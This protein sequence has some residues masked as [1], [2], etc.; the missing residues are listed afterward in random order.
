M[1][2][3]LIPKL[4]ISSLIGILLSSI[5][6]E[7]ASAHGKQNSSATALQDG[8]FSLTRSPENPKQY[9]LVLSDGEEHNI[10]GNFSLDQLQILRVIMT[11]AEKFALNGEAVG[12]QDPLTTR[13]TDKEESAFL[14]DVEKLGNQSRLFLT[15]KT[16]I[17]RTTLHA[18]R[19]L[20]STKREDGFFFDLLSRLESLLP[21]LPAQRG[22]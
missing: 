19:V 22:K 7:A 8:T 15:L 5:A 3:R 20:R 6:V 17:G 21:K 13:F 14:V 11:E 1:R 4:L 12:A 16:E 18:G 2:E 10:S 9:S